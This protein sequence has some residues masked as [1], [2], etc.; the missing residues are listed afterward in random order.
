MFS[1]LKTERRMLNFILDNLNVFDISAASAAVEMLDDVNEKTVHYYYQVADDIEEACE[2]REE[3]RGI[4]P[5]KNFPT[6]VQ[7][8][9]Y[10]NEIIALAEN[11]DNIKQFLGFEDEFWNYLKEIERSIKVAPEVAMEIAYVNALVDQDGN[12]SA[13]KLLVPEVVDLSTALLAIKLYRRAYELYKMIGNRYDEQA[14]YDYVELQDKF[15]NRYLA[16]KAEQTFNK[17]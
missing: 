8:S 13:I 2:F 16:K 4:R 11:K 7:T 3:R 10:E 17:K 12:V 15:Q 14:T 1:I 5:K 9:T 6:L